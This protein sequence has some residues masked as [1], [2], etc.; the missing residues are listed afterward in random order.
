MKK[1]L[2]TGLLFIICGSAIAENI[3]LDLNKA[4]CQKVDGIGKNDKMAIATKYQVPISSVTFIGAQ[5]GYAQ[6][7]EDCVFI[8]DTAKG[9][10]KCTT[11]QLLSDDG[12][13]TAFGSVSFME[14][15]NCFS[16]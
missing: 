8:F 4:N 6:Y 12:G 11:F 3:K 13:K 14:N 7:G 1:T 5:W 15:A 2:I 16:K 9:P 10:K